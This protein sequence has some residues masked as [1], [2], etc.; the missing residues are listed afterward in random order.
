[1]ASTRIPN[2]ILDKII[3]S[4]FT[5]RQLKILL[6]IIRSSYGMNNPQAILSKKDFL[7]AGVLPYHVEEVVKRLVVRGVVKWNPEKKMFW[8][9]PCLKEW[10]DKKKKADSFRD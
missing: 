6:L 10:I 4:N 7:R 2:K 5:K 9:N 1:M 3:A 8:I